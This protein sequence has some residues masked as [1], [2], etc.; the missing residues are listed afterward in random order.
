MQRKPDET[1]W[2][3]WRNA[4][5]TCLLQNKRLKLL[6]KPL[7]TR[8]KIEWFTKPN[9]LSLIHIPHTGTPTQ[10]MQKK[11]HHNSKGGLR[12]YHK[13]P[14][15]YV[16]NSNSTEHNTLLHA[17]ITI[18]K[19]GTLRLA[20]S[21]PQYKHTPSTTP[22][23]ATTVEQYIKNLPPFFTTLFPNPQQYD[24]DFSKTVINT[25]RNGSLHAGAHGEANTGTQEI[26]TQ[27]HLTHHQ[28]KNRNR[29]THNNFTAK[30]QTPEARHTRGTQQGLLTILVL[31][32]ALNHINI[33]VDTIHH[34]TATKSHYT[35]IDTMPQDK[36]SIALQKPTQT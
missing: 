25:L 35:G 11:T 2:K 15:T 19:G 26:T 20:H 17:E 12:E 6:A 34:D 9:K 33:Q 31:L 4:I 30:C 23:P 7:G 27:W 16:T 24:A 8:Q 13:Q 10:H 5:R 21:S 29:I 28:D 14:R 32:E 1:A 36:D 22:A 3:I 18:Q